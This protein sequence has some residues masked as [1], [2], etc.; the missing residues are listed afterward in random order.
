M[1]NLE[2]ELVIT[3]DTNDADYVTSIS[4]VTWQDIVDIMPIVGVIKAW[5]AEHK[6]GHNWCMGEV[7]RN[8]ERPWD[9][10]KGLLTDEQIDLFDDYVPRG[11]YG[12]HTIESVHYYPL[13]EKIKLL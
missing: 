6:N 1:S 5:S 3:A 2:Y 13:P 12:V 11:E 4:Q 10:Y 8:G 7:S 9:I